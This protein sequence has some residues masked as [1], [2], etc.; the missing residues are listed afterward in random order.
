MRPVRTLSA[1]PTLLA[2]SVL[3]STVLLA[4]FG[5]AQNNTPR[6]P[7]KPKTAAQLYK[8][9]KVLQ[10]LPADRLIPVMFEWNTA[11]GVEC[12]YCHVI[13]ATN[14]GYEKEDKPAHEEARQMVLMTGDVNANQ[15][16]L[17][18]KATCY[19]CHHGRI[20]PDQAPPKPMPSGA[21]AGPAAGVR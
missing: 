9:I 5:A 21:P 3:V 12:D 20:H 4:V 6:P 7:R 19:M 14:T 16:S 15:K 13:S 10:D 17:H 2:I 1:R 18:G 11:L 8:N